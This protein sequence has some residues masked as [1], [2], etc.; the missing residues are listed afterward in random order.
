MWAPNNWFTPQRAIIMLVAE[1]Q[2]QELN[3]VVPGVP[4]DIFFIY[5]MIYLKRIE[6]DYCRE[7]FHSL[8]HLQ[9][10]AAARSEP[11]QIQEPGIP[12]WFPPGVAHGATWVISDASQAL[13]QQVTGI[14]KEVGLKPRHSDMEH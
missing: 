13:H 1:A 9:K 2:S 6:K 14:G 10:H 11:G 5:K 7:R 3:P 12:P 4:S 8:F